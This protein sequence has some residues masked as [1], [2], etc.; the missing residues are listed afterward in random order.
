MRVI[1][2]FLEDT[3]SGQQDHL[4]LWFGRTRA[5]DEVEEEAAFPVVCW[6]GARLEPLRTIKGETDVAGVWHLSR[7]PW[8]A[9]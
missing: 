4:D 3:E 9:R 7:Y 6:C 1:H 5:Q 2:V 8:G